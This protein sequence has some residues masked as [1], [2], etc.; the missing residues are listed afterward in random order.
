MRWG[1]KVRGSDDLMAANAQRGTKNGASETTTCAA[2]TLLVVNE[3]QKKGVGK[4][5]K[6]NLIMLWV[7]TNYHLLYK[8]KQNIYYPTA[9]MKSDPH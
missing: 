4:E 6:L 3:E 9:I 8:T 7:V 2:S 1:R 5:P